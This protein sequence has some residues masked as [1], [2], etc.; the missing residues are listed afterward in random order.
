MNLSATR[1]GCC[2]A[3]STRSLFNFEKA[4]HNQRKFA[5]KAFIAGLIA[6]QHRLTRDAQ[7]RFE[8]NLV[9][10]LD[11]SGS[12]PTRVPLARILFMRRM[13]YA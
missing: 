7:M 11:G 4:H 5:C 9:K 12:V 6:L 13:P 1:A 8:C 10:P 2:P 3:V